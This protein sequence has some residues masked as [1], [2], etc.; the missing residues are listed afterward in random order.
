MKKL[1]TDLLTSIKKIDRDL[2]YLLEI[3][4]EQLKDDDLEQIQTK[5]KKRK[6]CLH[7]ISYDEVVDLVQQQDNEW[8]ALAHRTYRLIELATYRRND[9]KDKMD[10][11]GRGKR[12]IAV[13][14]QLLK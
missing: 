2:T 1:L 3:D 10:K 6:A 14:Q 8:Q 5:I 11:R 7:Q 4:V 9:I 13:Y 12:S